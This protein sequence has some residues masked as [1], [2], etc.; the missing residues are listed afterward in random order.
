[1]LGCH[2]S[3]AVAIMIGE[4]CCHVHA[5]VS[6]ELCSCDHDSKALTKA[7]R[8]TMVGGG[9]GAVASDRGRGMGTSSAGM[10]MS[11]GGGVV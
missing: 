2:Q 10:E 9:N 8:T 5:R 7:Y 1:V 4:E 11:L 6:S 3:S